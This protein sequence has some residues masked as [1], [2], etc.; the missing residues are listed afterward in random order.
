LSQWGVENGIRFI[1]EINGN[2]RTDPLK[3]ISN[4][5]SSDVLAQTERIRVPPQELQQ[6]QIQS[7]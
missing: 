6:S 7:R 3:S 2:L 4:P 1:E 5:F